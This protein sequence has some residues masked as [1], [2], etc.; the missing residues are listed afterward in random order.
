M[1]NQATANPE[2][3]D[4]TDEG[5]DH[6][7][8]T[9]G[10]IAA[11]PPKR[12]V[13]L[14]DIGTAPAEAALEI[15]IDT[16][17]DSAGSTRSRLKEL[18]A[19]I[20]AEVEGARLDENVRLKDFS[21][22]VAVAVRARSELQALL[23]RLDSTYQAPP[24][25]V[26][27]DVCGYVR[28]IRRWK[29]G[30]VLRSELGALI[31][32]VENNPDDP[33]R[34]GL[35]QFEQAWM[36]VLGNGNPG[37]D[38]EHRSTLLDQPA[39]QILRSAVTIHARRQELSACLDALGRPADRGKL[40]AA[41]VAEVGRPKVLSALEPSRHVYDASANLVARK[42]DL[43]AEIAGL[44]DET[45]RYRARV[46]ERAALEAK[47]Q[48]A[49][50]SAAEARRQEAEQL[51]AEA[52]AGNLPAI[53]EVETLV[54]GAFPALAQKLNTARG[55]DSQLIAVVADLIAPPPAPVCTQC[56]R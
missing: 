35:V 19:R 21:R 28:S 15:L 7:A 50:A 23:A 48:S 53:I 34:P 4:V 46:A 29:S 40:V 3:P 47:I 49:T 43:D 44:D 2:F 9:L 12:N 56:G 14:P 6:V 13:S 37:I 32:R 11:L 27:G 42:R 25:N 16:F 24:V 31:K 36:E 22:R 1:S 39:D 10:R 8:A 54:S 20:D 38:K 30:N 18:N 5:A 52:E 17:P 41:A 45:D 26:A 55:S 33:K 51:I